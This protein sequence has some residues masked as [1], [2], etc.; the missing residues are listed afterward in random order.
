MR[1]PAVLFAIGVACAIGAALTPIDA[2]HVPIAARQSDPAQTFR[3]GIDLI[4]VDVSVLDSSRRPIRGLT[5]ADFTILEDGRPVPIIAFAPVEAAVPAPAPP[6]AAPWLHD[7]APDITAN[8][9]PREG[10]VVVIMFDNTL[11]RRLA[12]TAKKIAAAAID[13]LGPTDLAA[14]VHVGSGAPQGF[15]RD[16]ARLRAAIDTHFSGLIDAEAAL[17]AIRQPTD[18]AERGECPQGTCTLGLITQIADALRDIP[19]R[20][21]LFLITER[22]Q[23]EGANEHPEYKRAREAMLSALDVA[24]LTI[25]V[26]DPAG[27][28]TLALDASRPSLTRPSPDRTAINA[29]NLIRQEGMRYLPD[30]TGGRTVI[31]SN[32]PDSLVPSILEETSAYYT[33][34]FRP[35]E[36]KPDGR[37]HTIAV[38]VRRDDA[39]VHSRRAF[40]A[41]GKPRPAASAAAGAKTP[42]AL[43]DALRGMWPSS[44]LPITVTAAPFADPTGA[45]P[46]TVVTVASERT[47][48]A[49]SSAPIDVMVQAFDLDGRSANYHH[50]SLDIGAALEVS[51]SGRYEIYSSLPLDPGRYELR[52]GILDAASRRVGT[53]HTHIE[54]PDFA[55][56]PLSMSGVLLEALPGALTAPAAPLADSLETL[57]TTRRIFER[58]DV[59]TAVARIYQPPGTPEPVELVVLVIDSAGKNVRR[60]SKAV[61]AADFAVQPDKRERSFEVRQTLP[62]DQLSAGEYLLTIQA[63]SGDHTQ[64]RNVRFRMK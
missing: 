58:S 25:H 29:A 47:A 14:V 35:T 55:R 19:R 5:A 53:V 18:S 40:H 49:G 27:L 15:T 23:V 48:N 11:Q 12:P 63:T 51:G 24:N 26:M 37:L 64:Q 7:T 9:L 30:R 54:V 4:Q 22:I 62:I 42:A 56:A 17:A 3:S 16:R 13:A 20:K 31:N 46:I 6:G 61:G 1:G 32:D 38:R 43:R 41:G 8:D 59:V 36:T 33:L 39:K 21:T 44:D 60:E 45:R 50:Q 34:G 52:A 57:P 2:I 28:E 10:R